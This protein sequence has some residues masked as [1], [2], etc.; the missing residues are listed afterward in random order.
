MLKIQTGTKNEILRKVSEAVKTQELDK[1]IKLGKEMI[2]YI[3]NPNN[4]GVGLAA[5]QIGE[6]KRL[7]IVSLLRDREDEN[8][9]TVLMINPEI[10]E[11]SQETDIETEGCLS[12]PGKRGEV[13]RYKSIK[14]NYI[15]ENK[16]QKTL[17]LNG[18]SARIIQHEIDHL[19]GVLFVDKIN[20]KKAKF[21]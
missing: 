20:N 15:D 12:V 3:K 21:I 4:R 19:D 13:Q 1:Y 10:L 16:K 6:N 7:I 17:I 9:Q 2:K 11:K 14:L 5:P 8:Y 18:I